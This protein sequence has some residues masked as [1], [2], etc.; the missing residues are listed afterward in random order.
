[1]AIE[2]KLEQKLKILIERFGDKPPYKSLRRYP[3]ATGLVHVIDESHALF[4]KAGKKCYLGLT[5]K[6]W[7]A[8]SVAESEDH[9]PG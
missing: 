3:R 2:A 7:V 4:N 1:M 9:N 5:E 6:G 8:T